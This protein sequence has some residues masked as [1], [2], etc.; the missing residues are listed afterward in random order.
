MDSNLTIILAA[1]IGA[2]SG[3]SGTVFVFR[4][5]KKKE[6]KYLLREK[7]EELHGVIYTAGKSIF[8]R[9]H[10]QQRSINTFLDESKLD[11]AA[12]LIDFYFPELQDL[13]NIFTKKYSECVIVDKEHYAESQKKVLSSMTELIDALVAR[14]QNEELNR[15]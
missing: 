11:R 10:V 3:F 5:S 14:F 13:F 8:Y 1:L 12:Q 7:A 9:E 2:A 4:A 6:E 15:L